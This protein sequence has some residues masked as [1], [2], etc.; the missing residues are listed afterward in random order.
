MKLP[1]LSGRQKYCWPC[2]A[3]VSS[4]FIDGEVTSNWN[5][6]T[7]GGSSFPITMKWTAGWHRLARF[8]AYL[9]AL[10]QEVRSRYDPPEH[11]SSG[12]AAPVESKATQP[13]PPCVGVG[14]QSSGDHRS[15]GCMHTGKHRDG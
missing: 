6:P 1:L 2:S 5:I 13:G 10:A 11:I 15:W 9:C 12:C 8:G 14:E 3:W 7:G 4:S